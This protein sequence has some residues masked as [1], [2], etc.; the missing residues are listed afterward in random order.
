MSTATVDVA[1]AGVI[2]VEVLLAV[3]VSGT[4]GAVVSGMVVGTGVEASRCK[5]TTCGI[6]NDRGVAGIKEMGCVG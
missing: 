3:E 4:I 2:V 5:D 6:K 1:L